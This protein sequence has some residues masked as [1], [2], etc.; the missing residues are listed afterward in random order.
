M[1]AQTEL[2]QEVYDTLVAD[3][4]SFISMLNQNVGGSNYDPESDTFSKNNNN[5]SN[6]VILWDALSKSARS[7]FEIKEIRHTDKLCYFAGLGVEPLVGDTLVVETVEYKVIGSID[8]VVGQKALF[9]I[10][11]R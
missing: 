11:V 5:S 7:A 10:V 3:E 9:K 8:V 4:Y 1:S 6:S 2:Q